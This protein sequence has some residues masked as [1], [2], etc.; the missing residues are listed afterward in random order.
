MDEGYKQEGWYGYL[1]EPMRELVRQ[2]FMLLT[3]EEE[4][5]RRFDDYSFVVFP[6]AKA[7]EGFLKKLLVETGLVSEGRAYGRHFRIGRSLNPD[8]PKRYKDE[9]WLYDDF[10]RLGKKC[11]DVNL[12]RDVWK[13]WKEGR[14]LLFHFFRGEQ[15]A[16]SLE[17]A[18]ERVERF[19]GV[20]GRMM[21]CVLSKA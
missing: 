10:E 5:G 15:Q 19:G 11:G 3:R 8:L 13:I 6:I 9:D 21:R 4:E 17:E 2:S 18:G 1:E 14:N 20:M 7:Y 12:A 16:I